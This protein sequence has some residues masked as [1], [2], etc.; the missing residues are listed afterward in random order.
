MLASVEPKTCKVALLA[1]GISNEREVSLASG[2]GAQKA[3]EEAG[4]SVSVFDPAKKEDLKNL[5][6]GNFDVAFLCLHG[7]NGEDGAIQG[8][9]QTIGLP[10]TGSHIFSS[11]LAMDKVISKHFYKAVALNTPSSLTLIKDAVD[12]TSE[13]IM[14]I[15][16]LPCVVKAAS[17]GSAFGVHI[18]KSA[19]EFETALEATFSIDGKVLVERYI[20]GRELTVAVVG[21]ENPEALPAIE[22]IPKNEFYDYESKYAVGGSE[23]ICPAEI[24]EQKTHEIQECAIVAHKV[25]GCSGVSRSDFILD[26]EGT[27]WLL[28]TNTLPGMTE[29][30]LL[31]DAARAAGIPFSALCT[32]LIDCALESFKEK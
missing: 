16:G 4:F 17:E 29:T 24:T 26:E 14:E 32:R 10:Y 22:I 9:L 11:S 2:A 31:P 18:V 30:S 5:I 3:L 21:N 20:S 7:K 25:L 28:E 15:I 1:G 19:D 13:E 8:F 6:E 12:K 23:H 27:I